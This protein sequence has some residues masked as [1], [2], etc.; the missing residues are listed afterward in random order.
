MSARKKKHSAK[1]LPDLEHIFVEVPGSKET[2]LDDIAKILARLAIKKYKK[3]QKNI[4]S[5]TTKDWNNVY[6]LLQSSWA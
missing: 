1:G 6:N 5:K 3:F 2:L 4:K